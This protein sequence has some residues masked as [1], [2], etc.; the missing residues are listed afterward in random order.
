MYCTHLDA[1]LIASGISIL[2]G[3][4]IG[5]IRKDMASGELFV[6]GEAGAAE[7]GPFDVVLSATGRIPKCVSP[8]CL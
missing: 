7:I 2:P 3:F 5:G 6:S 8:S 4:Q 1:A